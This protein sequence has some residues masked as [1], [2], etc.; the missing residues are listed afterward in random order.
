MVSFVESS[1]FARILP[2]FALGMLLS[3]P[4]WLCFVL[5]WIAAVCL[6]LFRFHPRLSTSWRFRRIPLCCFALLWFGLGSFL[7]HEYERKAICPALEGRIHCALR[8]LAAPKEKPRSFQVFVRVESCEKKQWEGKCLQLAFQKDS[9]ASALRVGD[10]LLARFTPKDFSS[11]GELDYPAYMKKKGFCAGAYVPAQDWKFLPEGKRFSLKVLADRLGTSCANVFERYVE[12]EESRALVSALI[13]GRKDFMDADM[14]TQFASAGVAHI[15]AVSGMHVGIIYAVLGFLLCWMK[16]GVFWPVLKECLLILFLWA[17]A[18]LTGLSPSVVRAVL[19]FSLAAFGRCLSRK[20]SIW[21]LLFCS[22]FLMLCVKPSYISDVGFQL[23]YVA[24]ASIL[25]LMPVFQR[26]SAWK[27][28]VASLIFLS[29]S[30]QLGTAP[31][32]V[33]YFHQFPNYFL[34]SNLLLTPLVFL[35]TYNAIALLCLHWIPFL[36]LPLSFCL[37][38][39]AVCFCRIVA[40]VDAL[41]GA[42]SDGLYPKVYEV[43]FAYTLLVCLFLLFDK[44]ISKIKCIF[45]A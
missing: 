26:I 20:T 33:F 9:I 24:V 30:A 29:L 44:H 11:F 4:M 43:V 13:L 38:K 1:P 10:A 27:S 12:E 35:L 3:P 22:A 41:P 32:S 23:S 31:L 5:V 34:L 6:C 16:A 37:N 28:P 7:H 21:N 40:W 17:Y 39:M 2:A 19:M 18:L 15:L 45:T 36:C 14:K 42:V 8:V 25:W